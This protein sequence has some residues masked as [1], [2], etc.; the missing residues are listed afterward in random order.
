MK[1]TIGKLMILAGILIFA[2]FIYNG[3][4]GFSFGGFNQKA[5]HTAAASLK[6]ISA[7]DINAKSIT[8]NIKAEQRDDITAEL[9]GNA[10]LE[11]A[12]KGNTLQLTV[13][14][15]PF[16]FFFFQNNELVVKVPYEYKDDLS[17]ISGSGNVKISGG[18]LALNKVTLSSGSGTQKVDQLQAEELEVQG[19]S[20]N[21]RLKDV[22]TAEGD[23]RSTSGNTELENVTG[24]LNIK[25]TSGDLRA[26]FSAVDAPLSIKQTS[27]NA[28]LDLPDDADISLEATSTSGSISHSFSFDQISSDK[29]TLTGK[30]GNGK[31]KIDISLTS[32][33]VS[34]E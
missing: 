10:R 19:T 13:H 32:G 29:R 21:I 33:N 6:G 9:T 31:N 7:I 20:G 34:I 8:V 17:V 1:K 26:S 25:Q 28:K 27:G 14:P 18:R 24:R 3:A 12:E 4:G 5:D 23:I 11:S 22:R 15:K 2:C 30:N 16:Q